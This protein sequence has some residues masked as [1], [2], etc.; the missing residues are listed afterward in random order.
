MYWIG[1]GTWYS[2]LPAVVH[3][4]RSRKPVK[5]EIGRT[6]Q[7]RNKDTLRYRMI[8]LLPVISAGWGSPMMSSMV[9]AISASTPPAR[10]SLHAS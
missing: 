5:N 8:M 2:I 4:E 7:R 3:F 10:S 6:R 9:G 1:Y